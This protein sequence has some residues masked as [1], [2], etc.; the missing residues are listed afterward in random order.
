MTKLLSLTEARNNPNHCTAVSL[1]SHTI[2]SREGMQ[3]IPQIA[4]RIPLVRSGLDRVISR[5]ERASGKRIDFSR[6]YWT[7]PALPRAVMDQETRQIRDRLGLQPIVSITDHDCIDGVMLLQVL[8]LPIEVPISV[9]WSIPF[10]NIRLHLG[11]HNLPAEEA[12]GWVREMQRYTAEPQPNQLSA[13]LAAVNCL[14]D[15]LVILNHPFWNLRY[16]QPE[17]K[18]TLAMKSFLELQGDHIH[19]VELNGYR[20]WIEN[21]DVLLLAE[22]VGK[23]VVSGGDRHGWQPNSMLNLTEASTFAGFAREVRQEGISRVLILPEYEEPRTLRAFTTAEEALGNYPRQPWGH[24]RWT[25]RVMVEIDEDGP[26]PLSQCWIEGE[27][28]WVKPASG[29]VRTLAHRRFRPALRR[30]M[31]DEVNL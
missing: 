15:T 2:F 27:P 24:Q 12:R 16:D 1:H 4:S 22:S 5:F 20:T 10:E 21:R 13:I 19:A 11:I 17:E 30:A 3:F 6:M 28:W 8:D 18:H 29:L 23:P 31:A 7:P 14:P 25:D 9:E 26:Q